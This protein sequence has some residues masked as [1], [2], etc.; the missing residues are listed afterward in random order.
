MLNVI[1][2]TLLSLT[3]IAL[4]VGIHQ[5]ALVY[6]KVPNAKTT[7]TIKQTSRRVRRSKAKVKTNDDTLQFIARFIR[8]NPI[9]RES[10]ALN[11]KIAGIDKTPEVFYAGAVYTALKLLIPGV[12]LL[13]V[14]PY[15][16][17]VFFVLAVLK[18]LQELQKL[19]ERIKA[20]RKQIELDLPRFVYSILHEL[21]SNHDVLTI[22]ER[23]KDN[24]SPEFAAEIRITIA[25]MRSSNYEAA[26]Q[27][28]EGR[29]GSTSLSEVVRGLIEMVNSHDTHIY[30]ETLGFRFS[31]MQKQALRKE[32]QKIPAKVRKLSFGLLM[33]IVMTYAVVLG[34]QLIENLTVLF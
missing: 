7:R 14:F 31:E 4:A 15:A 25:D 30:W 5:L 3:E 18:F 26:L 24:F 34:I 6:F 28:L 16:S 12:I 8:L 17:P 33:C 11:L 27:R 29:V 1:F 20:K 10:V 21:K 2:F 9:K 32:A 13:F 22:L 23:H 19:D